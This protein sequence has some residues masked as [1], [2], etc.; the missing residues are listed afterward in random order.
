MP[1][2]ILKIVQ[3]IKP[4]RTLFLFQDTGLKML[5]VENTGYF[6]T[7]YTVKCPCKDK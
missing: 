6:V 5:R 4:I 7:E 1:I 2:V 3:Q